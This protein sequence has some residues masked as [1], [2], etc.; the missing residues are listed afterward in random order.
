MTLH[1]EGSKIMIFTFIGLLVF[2]L[3]LTPFLSE[4]PIARGIFGIFSL[5]IFGVVVQFFRVPNRKIEIRDELII[6]PADGKVVVIEK[7]FEDEYFKEE[8]IQ[9]SIF[10]S[11]FNVHINWAPIAGIVKYAKYHPGKFLVAWHPKSST[12]NER[13][14][15]VFENYKGAVLVRQIAG[16]LARRIVF[17]VKQ[18]EQI[19]Q[20]DEFGFIKFGSRVDLLLPIN[21][22]IKVELDQKVTGK[23]TII[24]EL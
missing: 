8:R 14:T 16:F 24:A 3:A 7:V 20:G 21:A 15:F 17:F 12:E 22:K 9:V 19:G 10:M 4:N 2:N 13:S 11:P 23:Q 5:F 18:D 1:R 6:S